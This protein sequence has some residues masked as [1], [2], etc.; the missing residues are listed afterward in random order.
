VEGLPWIFQVLRH[1]ANLLLFGSTVVFGLRPPWD[2]TWLALPLLPFALMF[3]MGVFV[4]LVRCMRR[5]SPKRA[6]QVLL[7]GVILVLLAGFV[8]TPFGADPSGRY[9]LPLAIP[10]SLFA[11]AMVLELHAKIGYW[12]V[13]LVLL[14][15]VYNL[16][17]TL[18]SALHFP[19]G[20][21]T[22]FYG[23]TQVD[24]RYD[25]PLIDFL[26]QH[27]ETR[28]YGNYWVTYPLA[29][30]SAEQLIFI[31]RL[32][33]HL[34]F[35]YTERDDRFLPY[36]NLVSQA[37]RVAYITTNHPDLD[38]YLRSKFKSSG[39]TWQEVQIGDYHVFYALSQP[40]RP[41]QIGLGATTNP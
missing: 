37:Q 5:D 18:Q 7:A 28:G 13:G 3:W 19:P 29:F 32:P 8:L 2:V 16:W 1:T 35:R 12:V 4:Y 40:V 41:A 26:R 27:G 22:Q 23:P 38:E 30:L 6:E 10:L 25:Q 31:P 17:G 34:D 24:H 39:I 36:D 11:A 20:V 33:Y 9:F 14:L 15:L 21:T